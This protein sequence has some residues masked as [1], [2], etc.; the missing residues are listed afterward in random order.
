MLPLLGSIIASGTIASVL[1]LKKPEQLAVTVE[2]C[3]QNIGLATTIAV[4]VD[5]QLVERLR[6]HVE[7]PF[8]ISTFGDDE[9]AHAAGI[10]VFYGLLEVVFIAIL[11]V[12]SWKLGYT[13]A[14]SNEPLLKVI[15]HNYQPQKELSDNDMQQSLELQAGKDLNAVQDSTDLNAD[16]E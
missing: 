4:R 15:M 14:P 1:G 3:Y 2:T 6:S 11:C 8:Q 12:S 13:F 5:A 10:P 9:G 16:L 7:F